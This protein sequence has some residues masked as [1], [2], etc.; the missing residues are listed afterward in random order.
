MKVQTYKNCASPT[1]ESERLSSINSILEEIR[2][3]YSHKQ[4][5]LRARAIG[6]GNPGYDSIKKYELPAVTWNFLFENNKSNANII[7]PTG[8]MFID[9]DEPSFDIN[10]VNTELIY[11]YFKSLGGNGY[12]LLVKVEGLTLKNFDITYKKVTESL[13]LSSLFDKCAKKATQFN[14]LSFDPNIFINEN[15]FEFAADN[16]EKRDTT[17]I[18]EKTTNLKKG[19]QP[20]LKKEKEKENWC[21]VPFLRLRFN[22]T[23]D[24]YQEDCVYLKEG[25]QY[26]ECLVPFDATGKRRAIVNGEKHRV[27]SIY[28]NNLMCLNPTVSN[29]Q[30]LVTVQSAINEYCVQPI[31]DKNIV[32]LINGKRKEQVEGRLLPFGVRLKKFWVDPSCEEKKKAYTDKRKQLGFDAIDAFFGDELYNLSEKVTYAVVAKAIEYS[33]KTIKRRITEEQKELMKEFN[34]QLKEKNI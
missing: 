6:K 16:S 23:L 11:S 32:A 7:A 12:G 8:L 34:K 26:Y 25:K 15:S 13:G 33:E 10:K 17:P 18:T 2:Y 27:L 19:T 21:S 24:S 9:I 20:L 29:E 1:V 28:I 3:G 31:P 4:T 5:I 30:I 14:V 22:L